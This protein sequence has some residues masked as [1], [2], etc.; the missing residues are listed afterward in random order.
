ML[1]LAVKTLLAYLLGSCA[2]ALLL[3][4]LQGVDIRRHG[5]GNAG[6]T[7]ALR[8]RGA[9][10]AAGVLL[11]DLG[12]GWVGTVL[13]PALYWPQ[14]DPSLGRAWLAVACAGAVVVGHVFPVWYGFR[15]GKGA[16]T[17]LGALAGLSPILVV[18]V[19][20]VWLAVLWA[21]G[22]VGL[23][24][25]LA[26][27]SFP[28]LLVTGA[29]TRLVAVGAERYPALLC[30]GILATLFTVYTHRANLARMRSGTENRARRFVRS[31]A[32]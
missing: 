5:S 9:P 19:V 29:S 26:S 12:K 21:T 30:F 14:A 24:T 13:V 20:A 18:P 23:A 1:E 8:T 2:G 27:L 22:Y 4:Q 25:M 28:L 16:A 11:I 17:L 32:R 31:G 15:G 6:A 10:F 3:G 7:N